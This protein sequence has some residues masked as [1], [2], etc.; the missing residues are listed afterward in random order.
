MSIELEGV[1]EQIKEGNGFWHSCTGCY[2]TED[3]HPV[4][5]YYYSET[6]RCPL[7]AGCRECGGI[8]AIW[9]PI[10]YEALI[11]EEEAQHA[12]ACNHQLA[13]CPCCG[14]PAAYVEIEPSGYVV[15]CTSPR[16]CVT[17]GEIR[18]ALG[19]DVKRELAETWNCR[20]PTGLP[21]GRSNPEQEPKA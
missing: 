21:E 19:G 7:G 4:G 16:P 15:S 1:A 20:L 8:G 12:A 9:D 6:L 5:H 3:G 17:T 10:D 13:P 14:S 11:A 2:E 18:Y